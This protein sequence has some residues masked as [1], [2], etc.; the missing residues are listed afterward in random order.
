LDDDSSGGSESSGG[1]NACTGAPAPAEVS[2]GDPLFADF[3][4]TVDSVDVADIDGDGDL[5]IGFMGEVSST[6]ATLHGDGAGGFTTVVEDSLGQGAEPTEIRLA[7]IAD[8]DVDVVFIGESRVA[9]MRGDGT[10]GFQPYEQQGNDT[11]SRFVLGDFTGDDVLDVAAISGNGSLIVK[12]GNATTEAFGGSLVSAIPTDSPQR[13]A[14]GDLN[15]DGDLDVVVADYVE[16]TLTVMLGGGAGLLNAGDSLVLTGRPLEIAVADFDCDAFPDVAAAFGAPG[17]GLNA[18]AGDGDGGLSTMP[19]SI[20]ALG[21]PEALVLV[22]LDGDLDADALV[23]VDD[24]LYIFLSN[25]DGTFDEP[26]FTSCNETIL[27]LA[28]GE[29]NGDDV[30]D[31]AATTTDQPCIFLSDAP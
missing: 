24:L 27:D 31:V 19:G 9:R 8:G 1:T 15:D 13:L 21:D 20:A 5:D 3:G 18:F 7:A 6:F 25:G 29:L 26:T 12:P 10:G 30:L 2:Y 11:V 4:S 14:A 23:A 17:S 22:D 28:V 16:E